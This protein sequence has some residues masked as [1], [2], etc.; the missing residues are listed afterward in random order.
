[1]LVPGQ[2]GKIIRAVEYFN[3]VSP[4]FLPLQPLPNDPWTWITNQCFVV[5]MEIYPGSKLRHFKEIHRRTG[6]PYEQMV[7]LPLSW[8]QRLWVGLTPQQLFFDDEHRNFEVESLGV[9][10][11]LV[12]AR[13]TDKRLFG[14]GLDTWRKRRGIKVE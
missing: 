2:D 3:T 11:C 10:M 5:Q 1:M 9:T 14:E 12:E 6:I 7:R 8:T 4:C 13:G